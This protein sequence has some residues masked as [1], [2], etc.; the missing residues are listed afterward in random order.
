[1]VSF[2]AAIVP[3]VSVPSQ[4]QV[5][6]CNSVRCDA[7]DRRVR[8]VVNA[9]AMTKV[10]PCTVF[11]STMLPVM[12]RSDI[13]LGNAQ[14]IHALV[15]LVAMSRRR[16]AVHRIGVLQGGYR[17]HVPVVAVRYTVLVV[18]QL[19]GNLRVMV[20]A[21]FWNVLL[22]SP[23]LA[24]NRVPPQT[25]P[26]AHLWR[27]GST[28]ITKYPHGAIG[29]HTLPATVLSAVTEATTV[30]EPSTAVTAAVPVALLSDS[31]QCRGAATH[32]PVVLAKSE[33]TREPAVW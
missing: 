14:R 16:V 8:G 1:M 11:W 32:E 22:S 15:A 17:C 27:C 7:A 13:A 18:A 9:R 24:V 26:T 33:S 6:W 28:P 4:G 10:A 3:V 31:A 12:R 29:D 19:A 23:E 25:P 20:V 30:S 5:R 2:K 21:R